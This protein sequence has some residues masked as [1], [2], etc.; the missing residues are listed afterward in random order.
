MSDRIYTAFD[1]R[2]TA[3]DLKRLINK[4]SKLED[5]WYLDGKFV[6]TVKTSAERALKRKLFSEYKDNLRGK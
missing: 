4:G 3:K 1:I 5:K 2:P 6:G